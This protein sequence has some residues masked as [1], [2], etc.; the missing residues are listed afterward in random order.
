VNT[1]IYAF[2]DN[3]FTIYLVE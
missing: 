2:Y 1:S 3:D